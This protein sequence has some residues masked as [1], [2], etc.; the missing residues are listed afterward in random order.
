VSVC[1]PHPFRSDGAPAAIFPTVACP[2]RRGVGLHVLTKEISD[3]PGRNGHRVR[4]ILVEA[5]AAAPGK[6]AQ[7][8]LSMM[9][10]GRRIECLLDQGGEIL[11]PPAFQCP[12]ARTRILVAMASPMAITELH[13]KALARPAPPRLLAQHGGPHRQAERSPP[14]WDPCRRRHHRPWRGR[15]AV[16]VNE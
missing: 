11:R 3:H 14:W 2:A 16:G 15:A 13:F 10:P 5:A 9:A 7:A 8:K 1:R 4:H 12:K 6:G